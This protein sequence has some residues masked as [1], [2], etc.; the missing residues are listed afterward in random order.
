LRTGRFQG[1]KHDTDLFPKGHPLSSKWN[2]L[3]EKSYIDQEAEE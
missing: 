2:A 3:L 1:G